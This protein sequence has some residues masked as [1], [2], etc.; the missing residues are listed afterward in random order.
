MKTLSVSSND[1]AERLLRRLLGRRLYWIF[2]PA[3]IVEAGLVVSNRFALP[4]DVHSSGKSSDYLVVGSTRQETPQDHLDYG[5]F[6]CHQAESLA[7]ACGGGRVLLSDVSSIVVPEQNSIVRIRIGEALV[8]GERE[9]IRYD[10][11]IF[12]ELDDGRTLSIGHAPGVYQGVC[13]T[14]GDP[15][16]LG[17]PSIVTDRLVLV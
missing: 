11:L 5:C 10:A 1:A 15:T 8:R 6:E 14:F 3:F 7:D 16:S 2:G 9:E 17:N 12:L 13:A 4:L